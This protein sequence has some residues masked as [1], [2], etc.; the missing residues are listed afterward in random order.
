MSL[1]SAPSPYGYQYHDAYH[2]VYKLSIFQEN[3]YPTSNVSLKGLIFI[4]LSLNLQ[5]S[6]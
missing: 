5:C 6:E 2:T 3:V 4:Y 1:F